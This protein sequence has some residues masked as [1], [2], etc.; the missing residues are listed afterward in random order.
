MSLIVTGTDSGVGKTL[1]SALLLHRY[2]DASPG[3]WKPIATGAATDR[4]SET[5]R[6]LAPAGTF[7]GEEA[8]LYDSSVSPHVA[9]RWAQEEIEPD[10]ILATFRHLRWQRRPRPWV[11][12]GTGGLLVPLRDDSTLQVDLF[13]ALNLPAVLVASSAVGTLNHT[14]LSLEAMNARGLEV[15]GVVMTGRPHEEHR[16]AIESFSGA[17]VLAEVPPLES[18]DREGLAWAARAIDPDGLLERCFFEPLDALPSV[19][20]GGLVS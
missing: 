8:Y 17:P 6:R 12:E 15:A 14:F 1:V 7:V 2:G 18:L 16:Q 11:V 20:D 5:V 3:Y 19:L 13:V 9:A 10:R 4:D